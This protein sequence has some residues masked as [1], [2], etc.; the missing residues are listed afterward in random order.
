MSNTTGKKW[1]TLYCPRCGDTHTGYSG[2]LDGEKQ[3]YVVCRT[4]NKKIFV[5][6]D[7]FYSEVLEEGKKI[8]TN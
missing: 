1:G 4:T 5:R 3:E 2:K 8:I 6:S 7:H